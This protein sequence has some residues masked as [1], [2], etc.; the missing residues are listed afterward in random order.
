MTISAKIRWR[1]P[2]VLGLAIIGLI[3][4]TCAVSQLPAGI[5]I[6]HVEASFIDGHSWLPHALGS[7]HFVAPR[8][9]RN[10]WGRA[11]RPRQ[12]TLQLPTVFA[13]MVQLCP[14]NQS[15]HFSLVSEVKS[16]PVVPALARI[17]HRGPPSSFL[18]CSQPP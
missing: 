3:A 16:L 15:L 18:A 4:T 13:G 14:L 7:S 11:R 17:W 2:I 1:P 8:Q 10:E 12:E 6:R 9:T 5:G